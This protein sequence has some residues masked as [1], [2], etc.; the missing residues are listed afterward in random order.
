VLGR[1]LTA[2]SGYASSEVEAAFL[3]RIEEAVSCA[4]RAK[5]PYWDAEIWRT[6]GDLFLLARKD[7]AEAEASL[8]RALEVARSQ[9][10]LGF[11]LR[12]ATSL[13]RAARGKKARDEAGERLAAIFARFT[14]G[15]D[16]RD[17]REAQDLLG[18]AP[19]RSVR[20]STGA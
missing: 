8:R 14:E 4:E 18:R 15:F 2:T 9:G 17:L 3:E 16:T 19:R 20:D 6:R 5:A 10:A 12:A 11:E 1:A 7:R 13:A